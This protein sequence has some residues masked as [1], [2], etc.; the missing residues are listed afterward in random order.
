MQPLKVSQEPKRF[1]KTLVIAVDPGTSALSLIYGI[2]SDSF[3]ADGKL[4]RTMNLHK[5]KEFEEWPGSGEGSAKGNSC[6]PTTLIYSISSKKLLHW[7][8]DA[9]HHIADHHPAIKRDEELVVENLKLLLMDYAAVSCADQVSQ[10]PRH[11][12]AR[13]KIISVLEK[14]P[15]DV[16]EDFL[17]EIF[18][19]VIKKIKE[20]YEAHEN[21][22]D[23]IHIELV[24]CFPSGWNAPLHTRVAQ[25]S[26][27]AM[28]KSIERNGLRNISFGLEDVYTE[29]ETLCG[30]KEWLKSEYLAEEGPV[31]FYRSQ[32]NLG[33]LKV[34]RRQQALQYMLVQGTNGILL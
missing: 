11:R 20:H 14:Q 7:G 23:H 19:H 27:V 24:I 26:V 10:L 29:S 4:K 34:S 30:V 3:T 17:T 25:L 1:R 12:E 16:F 18:S 21:F 31:D 15:C 9:Q 8:F 13:T 2:G 33:I 32:S 5:M 6:L 28:W 22:L